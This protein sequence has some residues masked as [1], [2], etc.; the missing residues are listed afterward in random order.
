MLKIILYAFL[1]MII[2]FCAALVGDTHAN[3][4]HISIGRPITA[5]MFILTVIVGILKL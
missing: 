3:G 2:L 1:V 4:W 5:I